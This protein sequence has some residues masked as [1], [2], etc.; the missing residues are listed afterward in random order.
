MHHQRIPPK[1][2]QAVP[3]RSDHDMDPPPGA[4][5]TSIRLLSNR[6]PLQPSLPTDMGPTDCRRALFGKPAKER[7][8]NGLIRRITG[9]LLCSITPFGDSSSDVGQHHTCIA[10]AIEE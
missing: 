1:T 5:L 2:T 10:Q 8:P 6:F 9:E 7:L 4:V 3:K